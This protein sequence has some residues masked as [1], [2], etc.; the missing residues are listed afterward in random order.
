[1]L[2]VTSDCIE[3]PQYMNRIFA[4]HS[5]F[6]MDL[7]NL[8]SLS[9]KIS[10]GVFMDTLCSRGAATGFVEFDDRPIITTIFLRKFVIAV[11]R[12]LVCEWDKVGFVSN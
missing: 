12:I 2:A 5:S 1:M 7:L 6:F 9:W 4:R 10:L 11:E 8:A 3:F